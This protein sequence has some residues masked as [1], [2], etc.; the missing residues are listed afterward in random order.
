[1]VSLSMCKVDVAIHQIHPVWSWSRIDHYIISIA[2]QPR[3][4][5]YFA[6]DGVPKENTFVKENR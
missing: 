4:I 1:M 6:D 3:R 5:I 2:Y